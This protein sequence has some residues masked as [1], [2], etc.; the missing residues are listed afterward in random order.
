MAVSTFILAGCSTQAQGG[1]ATAIQPTR[2]RKPGASSTE[3]IGLSS[4]TEPAQTG[5][6]EP[7]QFIDECPTLAGRDSQ[8]TV[9][10]GAILFSRPRLSGS[11]EPESV[12]AFDLGS[13]TLYEI[14]KMPH[15]FFSWPS[16]L[17]PNGSELY[18]GNVFDDPFE[19]MKIDL[20][21][22]FEVE[23]FPIHRRWSDFNPWGYTETSVQLRGFSEVDRGKITIDLITVNTQ[24][25]AMDE[26]KNVIL[27]P[28][29]QPAVLHPDESFTAISHDQT[30]VIYTASFDEDFVTITLVL[31]SRDERELRWT[32]DLPFIVSLPVPAWTQDSEKAAISFYVDSAG[33]DYDIFLLDA[34]GTIE[35]IVD[36]VP[37]EGPLTWVN[38][39]TWSPDARYIYFELGDFP[40][41]GGEGFVVDTASRTMKPLCNDLEMQSANGAWAS[42]LPHV[43]M[44]SMSGE[45]DLATFNILDVESWQYGVIDSAIKGG[46]GASP[47]RF[48]GYS[49]SI[50]VFP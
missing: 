47:Y 24:S 27:L 30:S 33:S 45:Q 49:T 16:M 4:P 40:L 9:R 32:H 7:V 18:V 39:M 5:T 1:D 2:T 8:S 36:R 10:T 50:D 25:G 11:L 19:L 21:R 13:E 48:L 6:P 34:Q 23:T 28:N 12:L 46:Y 26:S 41:Y 20:A 35:K 14:V 29:F 42:N 31:Y 37:G 17:S 43:L 38:H 22:D 44:F 15:G 3:L